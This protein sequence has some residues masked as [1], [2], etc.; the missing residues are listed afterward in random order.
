VFLERILYCQGAQRFWCQDRGLE[1]G[2]KK[3]NDRARTYPPLLQQCSTYSSD[4]GAHEEKPEERLKLYFFSRGPVKGEGEAQ[5]MR[6][7]K[8]L[9]I[10]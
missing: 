6:Q 9:G 5:R 2:G 7:L 3:E 1:V 8:R 10:V 4:F